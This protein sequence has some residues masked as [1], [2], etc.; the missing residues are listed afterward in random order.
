[1]EM[2]PRP[3]FLV[4]SVRSG[5]T[6]LRLMLDHHPQV[7]FLWEFEY[8]IQKMSDAGEHP[9]L[10]AFHR[11]LSTD[12]IFRV[13]QFGLDPALSYPQLVDG[14]L[15]QYRDRT[16]K[17]LVGATV[18][19]HFDRVLHLWPDARFIHICRDGRDVARS[20][21]DMGWAGNVW[22][23]VEAWIEAEALW[24]RLRERLT[25]DRY[26]EVSY[27]E[28]V[29]QPVQTL[30]QVCGFMGV[31]YDPAMLDYSRDS[32]YG[33]PDLKMIEQWKRKLSPHEVRLVEARAGEMLERRGYA[34]SG[35]PPLRLTPLAVLSLRLQDFWAVRVRNR[36]AR[37]GPLL[38]GADLF[39]RRLGL[40][41][42]HER[43]RLRI[44]QID[45]AYIK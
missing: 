38:F 39:A 36:V 7:A 41:R 17:S 12:R 8:A 2:I 35:R 19:Y 43:V 22:T 28:L 4:G 25:P 24:S 27:E 9:P 18:H 30:E 5:T 32:T 14:F 34:L 3:V 11:F 44:N 6:L 31:S 13:S 33:P 16:G 15:R 10:P 21:I 37:Y 1:M 23:G 29:R 45:M 42:L 20:R 40:H 26:I